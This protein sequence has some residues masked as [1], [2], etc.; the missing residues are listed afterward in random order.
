MSKILQSISF[1]RWYQHISLRQFIWNFSKENEYDLKKLSMWLRGDKLSLN[2]EKTELFVFR[3]QNTKLNNSFKIK[4]DG[5]WLIPTTSVKYL[6]VLLDEHL[7]WSP[8]ISH[9]QIKLNGA[10]GILIKLRYQV[11]IYILKMVYNHSIFGIIF[12]MPACFGSTKPIWNPPKQSIKKITFKSW[13]ESTDPLC[14]GI[15]ILKFKDLLRLSNRLFMCQLEQNKKLAASF[16]G[17]V[18]AKEK[19]NYNTRSAR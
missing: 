15:K 13:Y 6:G 10:I 14:R 1:C 3:R 5:K 12:F 16:L 18:Y 17:L 19:H 2:V 7:T 9:A 8:Q 4:L 11:N